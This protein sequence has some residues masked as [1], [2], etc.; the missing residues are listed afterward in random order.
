[1]DLRSSTQERSQ[2]R[3]L[4][5]LEALGLKHVKLIGLRHYVHAHPPLIPHRHPGIFELIVLARGQQ[6]YEVNGHRHLLKGGQIFVTQPGQIHGTAQEVEDKGRLYW[7]ELCQI[8]PGTRLLGLAATQSKTI[9]RRLAQ[10]PSHPFGGGEALVATFERII[11]VASAP[12]SPLQPARLTSLVI[13]LILDLL[14]L[15]E[16]A[17]PRKQDHQIENAFRLIEN[18]LESPP[19]P[20]SLARSA[21]MSLSHFNEAF[22][23]LTG[24]PPA[25]YVTRR[26]VDRASELLRNSP[27]SVTEIAH[28]L[29]FE[30]S[31]HFAT[32]FKRFTG[33][34]PGAFRQNRDLP[35][36][37]TP[38][39]SGAGIGFHPIRTP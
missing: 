5:A 21:R 17:P 29:G 20:E 39:L 37:P 27:R 9:M 31:Q 10:L 30:S 22:R 12:R 1:M 2:E 16:A 13:Q 34:S 33:R 18:N 7:M 3:S 6:T 35:P 38:V 32:V 14:E 11:A 19:S 28:A 25:E 23:K 4:F 15:A 8:K 24:I 26:R 36:P